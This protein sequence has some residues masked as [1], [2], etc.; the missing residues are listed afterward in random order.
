[1][2]EVTAGPAPRPLDRYETRVDG[3]K[4]LIGHLIL[5]EKQA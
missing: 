5:P 3:K 4:L 1:M 2:T